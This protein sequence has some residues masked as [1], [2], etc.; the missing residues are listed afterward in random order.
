MENDRSDDIERAAMTCFWQ[1]GYRGCS[2]RDLVTATGASRANLYGTYD[3]KDGLFRACLAR[4]SRDIVD[5]AF[6][7]VEAENADLSTVQRYLEQQITL[8]EAHGLPGPGCLMVNTMLELA[9]HDKDVRDLVVNHVSRLR[10]GFLCIVKNEASGR[11]SPAAL[12]NLAEYLTIS[13]Q[14]L[15]AHSRVVSSAEPLRQ[16]ADMMISTVAREL[17]S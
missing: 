12:S 8:A 7:R 3:D 17:A 9:P 16:Y 5:P 10:S 4:Y 2:V 14:G 11:P 1:R 15:W 6:G 13:T